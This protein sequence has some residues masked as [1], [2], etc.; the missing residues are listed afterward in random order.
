LSDGLASFVRAKQ[1]PRG[2]HIPEPEK[3][4]SI[5]SAIDPRVHR[6]HVCFDSPCQASRPAR[7][8]ASRRVDIHS[9]DLTEVTNLLRRRLRISS[10]ARRMQMLSSILVLRRQP[11]I[12]GLHAQ[13][14]GA[15]CPNIY[16][17]YIHHFC[18]RRRKER[19]QRK[20]HP[21]L[22]RRRQ[23]GRLQNYT[24]T[25]EASVSNPRVER[26]RFLLPTISLQRGMERLRHNLA[27]KS[28]F[29]VVTWFCVRVTRT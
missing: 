19:G 13:T 10:E 12:I 24:R 27:C 1:S 5:A 11:D 8:F 16:A 3:W 14:N 29:N 21:H 15:G 23:V 7:C 18:F 26:S 28:R 4:E 6:M 20:I 9:G 22:L 17:L 25:R 2:N